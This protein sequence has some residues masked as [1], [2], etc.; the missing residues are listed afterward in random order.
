MAGTLS[1]VSAGI[2]LG[3]LLGIGLCLLQQHFGIVRLPIQSYYVDAV[4]VS[5]DVAPILMLNIGTLVVCVLALVLP[6]F[7]VT[8]VAPA[9]A[10]RFD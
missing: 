6:S 9:K 8:R 7:L 5:L 2:I 10:I 3:D 4:P 1:A